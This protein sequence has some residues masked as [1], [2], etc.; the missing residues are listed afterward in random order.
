MMLL[1]ISRNWKRCNFKRGTDVTIVATGL[2]V[3]ESLGIKLLEKDG[4]SARVINIHTIKPLDEELIV[5]AAKDE[6]NRYSQGAF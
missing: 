1:T 5:A 3:S 2:C 6:K 4:I